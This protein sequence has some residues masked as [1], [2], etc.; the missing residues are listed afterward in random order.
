MNLIKKIKIHCEVKSG[1]F[2]TGKHWSVYRKYFNNWQLCMLAFGKSHIPNTDKKCKIVITGFR[3][4]RLDFD[5]FVKG[6]KPIPDILKKW[7]WLVD[8]RDEWLDREYKQEKNNVNDLN[9]TYIE[10]YEL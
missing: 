6:C 1:N 10:L 4:R 5:N 3:K 7:G 2:F 9:C 8:D